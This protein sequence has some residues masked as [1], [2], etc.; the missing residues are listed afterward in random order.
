MYRYYQKREETSWI[1]I[2]DGPDAEK[3][4]LDAGARKLTILAVSE[5]IDEETANKE[6]L[7]YKGPLYFDIDSADLKQSI[8]SANQ[9]VRKL[10]A[11]DVPEDAVQ[12]YAS[13]S[14]GFHILVPSSVFST[15]RAQKRLPAVYKEVAV[16]LHVLGLDFQVYSEGRG[17]SF[18]L[19]NVQRADGRYRVAVPHETLHNLTPELYADLTAQPGT[20]SHPA[21]VTGKSPALSAMM[22]AAKRRVQEKPSKAA[23]PV[24]A[25]KLVQFQTTAPMCMQELAEYRV[26]KSANFNIAALQLA[27]FISRSGMKEEAA[28]SLISRM[29]NN[30]GSS[31]Y[32]SP[33]ARQA[34]IQGLVS[35]CNAS[36]GKYFA[37]NA[38][39]SVLQNRVCDDCPLSASGAAS[40]EAAYEIGVRERPDGYYVDGKDSSY[41]IST[42][43]IEPV[44]VYIEQAQNGGSDR[45]VGT[46]VEIMREGEI[47]GTVMFSETGWDSKASLKAELR[48]IHNLSFTGTEDDVQRI[49]HMVFHEGKDMGEVV[50][51]HTAGMHVHK[52]GK[53]EL[54]V[55]VEPGYS[56]NQMKISGTHVLAGKLSAPPET[57]HLQLP[58][59]GDEKATEALTCLMKVNSDDVVAQLVGWFCACHL[60]A[61]FMRRY[62][63]FPLLSIWGNAGSGKSASASL[64]TWLN[65]V[66]Y[67]VGHG[68]LNLSSL[69]KW[70]MINYCSGT[71]T[72]PRQLEEYN[73][74]KM[75]QRDYDFA[76][77]VMKAAWNA[78]V[79]GRGTISKSSAN[80]R[81]RTGA[82]MVELAITSPLVIMSEQAPQMAALQQRSIQ[83]MLSTEGKKGRVADFNRASELR[84]SLAQM[85]KAMVLQALTTPIEWVEVQMNEVSPHVPTTF[86]E[87]PRYSYQV[88]LVGLRFLE[89]V[90]KDLQ[91]PVV[92]RINEL[93]ASLVDTLEQRS[94]EIAKAKNRTEV[95][96][97]IE[98]LG[99]MATMTAGGGHEWMVSGRHFLIKE[100]SLY[101]DTPVVH[102]MYRMYKKTMR[103][104]AVIDNLGQ[105]AKLLA[106][107]PYFVT[108]KALLPSMV[109][110]RPVTQ[111]NLD[112]MIAKGIEVSMFRG[113]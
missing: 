3:R 36:E 70:A 62:T 7:S 87:R 26:K 14:K 67:A 34:H 5:I 104:I 99:V 69:T 33:R 46:L 47:L 85:A 92:D 94:E 53:R 27:T 54:F 32:D 81:G 35:Y 72:V 105:F 68:A 31:K 50:Q 39:R 82:E 73:K 113:Q 2:P 83:V 102:A 30:A 45:R 80:G 95:D 51:V 9:L 24:A 17:N 63:Q 21:T 41:R 42:F 88:L 107:E 109:S 40:G 66:D 48:G 8:E 25:A 55:Y 97:V 15:G 49:K 10:L 56:I 1:P 43:T 6:A 22:E 84:Q 52:L 108:D 38:V 77:E 11:L 90:C 101:L 106:Q 23:T 13:G 19:A 28:D 86:M 110:S 111:L 57:R 29:A 20:F 112:A 103:D 61:H 78:N 58:A 100:N 98:D 44:A 89:A 96:A 12:V 64:F 16:D 91:L 4:A 65:G 74:S 18:R 79:M 76:G 60:K 93:S 37:C 71:T 59:I 75:S